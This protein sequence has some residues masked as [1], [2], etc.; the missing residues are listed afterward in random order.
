MALNIIHSEISENFTGFR[1]K[2]KNQIMLKKIIPSILLLATIVACKNNP[3]TSTSDILEAHDNVFAGNYV[4]TEYQQRGEGYDWVA[5]KVNELTDSILSISVRSRADIKNPTCTF[6]AKAFKT[7]SKNTFKASVEGYN[8]FFVFDADS[9]IISGE[10][11]KD[12]EMLGYFCSGGA[13]LAGVYRKITEPLDTTQIDKVLFRKALNYN[14]FNFFIEVYGKKLTI[15]PVGLS[16]DNSIAEHQIEGTV[17][18]AEVGDLNIDGFPELMIYLQSDG[19]GSYGSVI[20][21]SVNNGKSMSAINFPNVAENAEANEGY[22]GHDEFAIV[23]STFNQRF[24]IYK[25]GD[26]NAKP[27]G[28]MRQIQYKLIDGEAMRQLVVDKIVEY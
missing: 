23:E 20:G 9:L 13:S 19:S 12:N 21:Y 8:V 11:E 4:T 16:V 17:V 28:G 1:V 18:N 24:P 3:K 27:T 22:M 10:T 15:Q 25:P 6:D 14:Q 5:V 2:F 26:S 7:P